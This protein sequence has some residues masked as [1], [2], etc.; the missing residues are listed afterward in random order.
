MQ[1][2][3]KSY[4]DKFLCPVCGNA[5]RFNLNFLSNRRVPHCDGNQ[6]K[7]GDRLEYTAYRAARL[8]AEARP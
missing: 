4:S 1:Y 2:S 5:R 8:Q 6:I 3:G 7:A